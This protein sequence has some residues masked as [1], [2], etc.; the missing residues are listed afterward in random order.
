MPTSV[1][2]LSEASLPVAFD[3][4]QKILPNLILKHVPP[5]DETKNLTRCIAAVLTFFEYDVLLH[6]SCNS[7]SITKDYISSCTIIDS[8]SFSF[9]SFIWYS[10]LDGM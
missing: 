5:Q 8:V 3:I 2:V 7:S 4:G 6:K 10:T 1:C 9:F